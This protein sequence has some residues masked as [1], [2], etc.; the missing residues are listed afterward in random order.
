LSS[1][2]ALLSNGYPVNAHASYHLQPL[3]RR[4]I[5]IHINQRI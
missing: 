2:A 5:G 3:T 4:Q 1:E